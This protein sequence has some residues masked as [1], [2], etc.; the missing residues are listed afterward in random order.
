M[1][2][3]INQFHLNNS[4]INK[5]RIENGKILHGNFDKSIFSKT[6]K[7]LIHTIFNDYGSERAV[8]FINDLQK[9]IMLIYY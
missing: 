5:I 3:K 6:S 2:Y 1:N 8:D 4:K 9:I 7:G